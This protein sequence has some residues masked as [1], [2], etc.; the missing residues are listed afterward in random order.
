MKQG[1]LLLLSVCCVALRSSFCNSIRQRTA[2][3]L[4]AFLGMLTSCGNANNTAPEEKLPSNSSSVFYPVEEYFITQLLKADTA[5]E[6]KYL[7]KNAANI[8]DSSVIDSIQLNKLAQPFFT[9][10]INDTS[11]KKYYRE[12]IFHDAT[13]ASNTFTYTSVNRALPIQSLDI[14]LDTITDN[15]KHVFIT[16][17]YRK[18]D[19]L[20]NEK[21]TWKTD[22]YFSIYRTVLVSDKETSEQFNI[23][24]NS[25]Q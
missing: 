12:S 11:I 7:H 6:I 18:G 9:D 20:I 5:K 13:T 22:L 3:I 17:A 10:Q 25:K 8:T 21:L 24:W 15:V 1:P 4:L 23:S 19:T 14:L 2:Y 16:K